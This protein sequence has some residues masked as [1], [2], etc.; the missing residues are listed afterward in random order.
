MEDCKTV[1][2]RILCPSTNSRVWT[3]R[4][5][6]TVSSKLPWEA[7]PRKPRCTLYASD[8]VYGTGRRYDAIFYIPE[9][10]ATETV[11]ILQNLYGV[12]RFPKYIV[13]V[14]RPLLL[15]RAAAGNA[16]A[17]DKYRHKRYRYCTSATRDVRLDV[18]S[19]SQIARMAMVVPDYYDISTR[20]DL[21]TRVS[22]IPSSREERLAAH[23]FVSLTFHIH[24]L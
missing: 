3:V 6:V 16:K 11:A 9:G 13:A 17:V 20:Q 21:T 15:T 14:L 12:A 22:D 7:V 24:F 1:V 10:S 8:M 18:I 19:V 4:K 23:F 5:R 2:E